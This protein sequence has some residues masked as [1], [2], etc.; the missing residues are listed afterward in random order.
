MTD[1]SPLASGRIFLSYRREDTRHVVGRI[2]DRLTD[3]FG[4][5]RV[6]VDVD[7]IEPGQ[8]FAEAIQSAVGS[9]QVLLAL[10][11][12]QWL[13]STDRKGRRKLDDA[14]D[15]VRLE[16]QA[17]LDRNV[18][19]IPVL[20]D[21]VAMPT[22]EELPPSLAGLARRQAFELSYSRFRDDARR[23]V[24]L[25]DRLLAAPA[26]IPPRA[27]KTSSKQAGKK[28]LYEAFW[29][30][31]FEQVPTE[32]PGWTNPRTPQRWSWVRT[33]SPFKGGP[34]Y[35]AG[36]AQGGKLRTELYI[37]FGDADANTALF[38]RL[39]A[40]KDEIEAS[41]G[42]ALVWEDLP[43]KQACRIADYGQG[44]VSNGDQLDEY[45]DWFLDTG[46]RLRTAID[47]PAKR[48]GNAPAPF[49]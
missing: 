46:T 35:A 7:T 17:A 4:D 19:V 27:A 39:A 10:I 15:L 8:D 12:D 49:P 25:L 3:H 14:N 43:G 41:Y 18:R 48:L 30:R 20:V 32:Q 42:A 45:I 37:D 38:E 23:L 40:I 26:P 11:G 1:P 13:D 21:G 44:N 22:A 33:G 2:G 6:F 36:F 47:T 16:I 5:E 9:C 29:N 34:Y 31:F 24:G 28:P